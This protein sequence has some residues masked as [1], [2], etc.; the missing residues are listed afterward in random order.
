[1][2]LRAAD[3]VQMT[4]FGTL[5]EDRVAAVR[6]WGWVDTE[7]TYDYRRF[8]QDAQCLLLYYVGDEGL[9][10]PE[11]FEESKAHLP[12]VVFDG[13]N[14]SSSDGQEYVILYQNIHGSECAQYA[15]RHGV[16]SDAFGDDPTL[17]TNTKARVDGNVYAPSVGGFVD[18][19]SL[20]DS[21]FEASFYMDVTGPM[22]PELQ[23]R[24]EQNRVAENEKLR[25]NF[26]AGTT[27]DRKPA[28][29]WWWQ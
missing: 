1:M 13:L 12:G 28:R 17:R 20:R 25:T 21:D 2:K 29:K 4:G 5:L 9:A 19:R 23:A 15:S 22:T 7:I 8:M 24:Y 11:D 16:W 14:L 26:G 6:S 3:I 27:L 10:Y 18:G